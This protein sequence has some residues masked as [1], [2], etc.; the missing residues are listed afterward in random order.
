[1]VYVFFLDCR[2]F[3]FSDG[4]ILILYLSICLIHLSSTWVGKEVSVGDWIK[5]YRATDWYL[6]GSTL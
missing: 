6:P 5:R 3:S 2:D 1:M 4:L